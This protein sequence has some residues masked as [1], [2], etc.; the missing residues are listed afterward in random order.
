[1]VNLHP[2][3]AMAMDR[4]RHLATIEL[5][6]SGDCAL[7]GIGHDGLVYVEELY[8][9]HDWLAQHKLSLGDGLVKSVDEYYGTESV[10]TTLQM[11]ER[12][13]RPQ[14]IRDL[15]HL[16]FSGARRR[17]LMVDERIEDLVRPLS[18]AEKV[19]LVEYL[20]W[21]IDPLRLLGI[22]DSIIL[23][24][25]HVDDDVFVVCRRTRIAYRLTQATRDDRGLDFD[26][27]SNEI[28]LLHG[29]QVDA[30]ELPVLT[31]CLAD[32]DLCRP[33]DCMAVDGKLYIADGGEDEIRSAL[34]VFE[35][36]TSCGSTGD[37][38]Q[39]TEAVKL[40]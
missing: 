9:E 15:D 30:K 12:L 38:G 19:E 23:S 24:C 22:A 33:L 31:E 11:P 39:E 21:D 14:R 32:F 29:L 13:H 34:H 18:I 25:C 20:D 40:C 2:V 28:N 16:N 26:Y 6:H 10:D 37:E 27:D 17:G 1:M 4:L 35:I 7:L 3:A 8:G 5:S 36:G